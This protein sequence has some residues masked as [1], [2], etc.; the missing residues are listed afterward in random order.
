MDM[1]LT[2]CL[3][4]L[5]NLCVF[6]NKSNNYMYCDFHSNEPTSLC[7]P[8][9][10]IGENNKYYVSEVHLNKK[11]DLTYYEYHNLTQKGEC[12]IL[13][14]KLNA[15]IYLNFHSNKQSLP[16]SPDENIGE[17]NKSFASEVNLKS[18]SDLIYFEHCN[19]TQKGKGHLSV[20]EYFKKFNHSN[21]NQ[22]MASSFNYIYFK[23]TF[24]YYDHRKTFGYYFYN[25]Y[26]YFFYFKYL[27]INITFNDYDDMN[28]IRQYTDD[29]KSKE[30]NGKM[31]KY[32]IHCDFDKYYIF[33]N[34]KDVIIKCY[35]L[36]TSDIDVDYIFSNF[37]INMKNLKT[38]LMNWFLDIYLVIISVLKKIIKLYR[39]SSSDI[40]LRFMCFMKK[41][42]IIWLVN[43][44]DL[45]KI[46]NFHINV[47]YVEA[48]I[49]L[50]KPKLLSVYTNDYCNYY[51]IIN[52]RG[53]ESLSNIVREFKISIAIYVNFVFKF[54][55]N[56]VN[57]L[58]NFKFWNLYRYRESY[59]YNSLKLWVY[60]KIVC[61]IRVTYIECKTN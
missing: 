22:E 26:D 8:G 18:K 34:Y 2:L 38:E 41:V 54:L 31:S 44:A 29:F 15:K 50:V 35:I 60:P 6:T 56:T 27:K 36:R 43:L 21:N 55:F 48:P 32:D 51:F 33:R 13:S 59:K 25:A 42:I 39:I 14:Y 7:T 49:L 11:S 40:D 47:D 17:N 1:K 46:N 57:I 58:A 5:I 37:N 16:S 24:D 12:C 10:N 4:N 3:M 52:T 23:D 61:D 28:F 30:R 20:N 45:E 53:S 9:E 19:L